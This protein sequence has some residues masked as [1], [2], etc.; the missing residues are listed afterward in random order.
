MSSSEVAARSTTVAAGLAKFG[1]RPEDHVLIL[2][3]DGPGFAE[4]FSG[5]TKLGAVALPVN[6]LLT[7]AEIL[8]LAAETGARLAVGW[9]EQVQGITT[10]PQVQPLTQVD[11]SRQLWVA[12][13]RPH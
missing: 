11:W 12:T 7:A 10:D 8:A 9:A 13:L 2:L 3:P 4:I 5:I 6:P 1:V